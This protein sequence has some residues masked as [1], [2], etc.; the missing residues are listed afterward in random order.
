M[1]LKQMEYQTPAYSKDYQ[2]VTQFNYCG[3]ASIFEY[4][5]TVSDAWIC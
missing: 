5:A 4:L 3:L 1:L 2:A